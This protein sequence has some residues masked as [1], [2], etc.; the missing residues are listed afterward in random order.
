M[1][2]FTLIEILVVLVIAA[3]ITAV[4]APE[5]I[6]LIDKFSSRLDEGRKNYESSKVSFYEFIKDKDC[7]VEKND[8]ITCQ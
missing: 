3:L 6:S 5:S 2:G 7:Y 1:K 8:N 4:V